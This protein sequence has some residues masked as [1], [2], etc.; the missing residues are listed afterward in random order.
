M[1]RINTTSGQTG[2]ALCATASSLPAIPDQLADVRRWNTAV[3]TV[4]EF[5]LEMLGAAALT[6]TGL[7]LLGGV[8][9]AG[10]I[11]DA[12]FTTTH[13]AETLTIASHG[14][15][16]GDG[17]VRPTTDD[18]LPDGLAT[19]TDYWVI[20]VDDN[21]IKLAASLDDA[22]AGTAVSLADDGSGNHTLADTD[23]TE[24]MVWHSHGLLGPAAS[25]TIVFAARK[26]Y[27][28]RCGHRPNVVAYALSGTL[29]ASN[30]SAKVYAI[31][32]SK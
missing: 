25:G 5:D 3:G 23:D 12:A 16:T 32:T 28:I 18:T 15:S 9:H 27:T 21:T 8:L 2:I 13:A 29:S 24:I 26:G 30:V 19:D 6:A 11:A 10:T 22:F 17:P 7:E 1:S 14:L 20:K 31:D 4:A